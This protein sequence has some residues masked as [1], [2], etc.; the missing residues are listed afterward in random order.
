MALTDDDLKAIQKRNEERKERKAETT[1]GEWRYESFAFVDASGGLSKPLPK[2]KQMW[3]IVRPATWLDSV[4]QKYG[5][6][7]QD[8]GIDLKNIQPYHDADWIAH[9]HNDPGRKRCR[10]TT[11]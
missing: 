5:N 8:E 4:W 11:R 7:F 3:I 9:A 2:S 6:S 1:P 10:C